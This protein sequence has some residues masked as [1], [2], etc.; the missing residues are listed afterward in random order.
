MSLWGVLD[1][2][3]P[4]NQPHCGQHT[5]DRLD[6]GT[7]P[8]PRATQQHKR[9]Q[10]DQRF[11][12]F[13]PQLIGYLVYQ[14][15]FN[16]FLHPLRA[17]PGPLLMRTSRVPYCVHL[18]SGRLPF[19]VLELHRQYGSVVRIAPNE[20]VFADARA[21]RDIMGHRA[22]GEPEMQKAPAFYKTVKGAPTTLLVAD[23][24][25]HGRLRRQLAQGFSDRSMR[26]QQPII[27]R[28]VDL[29][30]KRLY[31]NSRGGTRPVDLVRC[32]P[33]SVIKKNK[34]REKNRKRKERQNVRALVSWLAD[35]KAVSL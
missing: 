20:L 22:P 17:F 32:K 10:A 16:I 6:N 13:F 4:R 34:R 25:E 14:V 5:R 12:P 18:L 33:F 9:A 7:L 21:W 28:Y 23:R 3:C 2:G 19:V 15:V 1:H 31:E 30:V 26:D 11:P 27:K 8:L 24:E 35:S 29:L